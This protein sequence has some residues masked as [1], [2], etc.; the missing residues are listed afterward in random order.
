MSILL[1]H[2]LTTI[3]PIENTIE[4]TEEMEQYEK[5]KINFILDKEQLLKDKRTELSKLKLEIEN[6]ES[7]DK[8]YFLERRKMLYLYLHDRIPKSKGMGDKRHRKRRQKKLLEFNEVLK[9]YDNINNISGD[10]FKVF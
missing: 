7:N 9:D 6:I 4:E 5:T 2:L 8:N 3:K 10:Y 1:K